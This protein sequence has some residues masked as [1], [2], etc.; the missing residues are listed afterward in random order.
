MITAILEQLCR[1]MFGRR[2]RLTAEL[3]M[4]LPAQWAELPSEPLQPEPPPALLALAARTQRALVDEGLTREQIE[5][6]ICEA[7]WQI[8]HA[9]REGQDVEIP[10][11]G[12]LRWVPLLG[13][14]GA[15]IEF[16]PDDGLYEEND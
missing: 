14:A 5:L 15:R 4:E 2:R 1:G 16:V 10:E 3:D 9:V 8:A 12:T 11:V 7:L 13:A 6:V